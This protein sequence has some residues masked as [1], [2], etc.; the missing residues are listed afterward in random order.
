MPEDYTTE[1]IFPDDMSETMMQ[2]RFIKRS[3]ILQ[4]VL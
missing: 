4:G 3:Y 2:L 1:Y